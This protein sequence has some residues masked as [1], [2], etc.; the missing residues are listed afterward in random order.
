MTKA[1]YIAMRLDLNMGRGKEIAQACHAVIGLGVHDYDAVIAIR[2][3]D[4]AHLA[5]LIQESKKCGVKYYVVKDAGKTVFKEPTI[6][7][8]A[9]YCERN[10]FPELTEC[11]AY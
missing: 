7:C 8:A 3:Y 6:T 1:I 5:F 9:L 11:K 10:A 4:E 2:A